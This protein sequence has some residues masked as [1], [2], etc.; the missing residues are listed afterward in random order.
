MQV[1]V[2]CL[3]IST[4]HNNNNI[5]NINNNNNIS[6][7]TT[8]F[9]LLSRYEVM[10]LISAFPCI[11]HFVIGHMTTF[12][13]DDPPLIQTSLQ[14]VL[15]LFYIIHIWTAAWPWH[16]IY[17]CMVWYGMV[18]FGM[19]WFGHLD[20]IQNLT[21]ELEQY[22][23][24]FGT[25]SHICTVSSPWGECSILWKELQH[26]PQTAANLSSIF[27]CRQLWCCV[28]LQVLAPCRG[29]LELSFTTSKQVCHSTRWPLKPSACK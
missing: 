10:H 22:I 29:F 25:H 13:N 26:M 15:E 19:V 24:Q 14:L 28:Q 9:F 7:T 23:M 1:A 16:H 21:I 11:H 8:N 27:M 20:L 6:T 5:N 3:L 2:K 17:N 4:D 18:W 12:L